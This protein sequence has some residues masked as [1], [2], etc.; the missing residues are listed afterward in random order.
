MEE[1]VFKEPTT[2]VIR[3]AMTSTTTVL[4]AVARLESVCFM[5]HFARTE[6]MPAK[7]AEP[8][9]NKIHI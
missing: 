2:S 6:V 5:P 7:K 3:N 8:K 1:I 9:A 4:V